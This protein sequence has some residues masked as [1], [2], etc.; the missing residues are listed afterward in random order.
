MRVLN[1]RKGQSKWNPGYQVVSSH[2]GALRVLDLATGNVIRV[3]QRHVREIPESK[4]YNEVDPLPPIANRFEKLPPQEATPIN[5]EPNVHIPIM[6]PP[7][8]M[9]YS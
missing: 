2:D 1:P 7:A 9:T 5:V 3:N 6:V 4:P 8:A